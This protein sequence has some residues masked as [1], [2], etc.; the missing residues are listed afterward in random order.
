MV[1]LR[2][3]SVPASIR[4]ITRAER[5]VVPARGVVL[6]RGV[7][8]A[9]GVKRGVMRGVTLSQRLCPGVCS[10]S[11]L[12][13]SSSTIARQRIGPFLPGVLCDVHCTSSLSPSGTPALGLGQTLGSGKPRESELPPGTLWQRYWR[14]CV[15][16]SASDGQRRDPSPSSPPVRRG[17]AAP[18][19]NSGQ[20]SR[21]AGEFPRRPGEPG[22]ESSTCTKPSCIFPSRD[23]IP[24][25]DT[26]SL[27]LVACS[28]CLAA[29]AAAFASRCSAS[30]RDPSVLDLL[31][32]RSDCRGV[33][34]RR[35]VWDSV[36]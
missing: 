16:L 8:L 27:Y 2:E 34:N 20:I 23:V 33:T 5:G 24:G 26:R 31:R 22:I 15:S 13:R 18:T 29:A 14:C 35:G 9:R 28:T 12:S 17:E 6:E 7:V 1:A 3:E 10:S 30:S 32:I 4:A 21:P 19:S 25:A 11:G 36:V